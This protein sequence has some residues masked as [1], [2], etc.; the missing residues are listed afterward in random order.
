MKV[1]KIYTTGGYRRMNHTSVSRTGGTS[2]CTTIPKA[3][4][5][6]LG[7]GVGD[8]LWWAVE[9]GVFVV[10]KTNRSVVPDAHHPL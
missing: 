6:E 10:R 8:V 2:L 4:A 3:L 7:V 9:G 5:R 1:E